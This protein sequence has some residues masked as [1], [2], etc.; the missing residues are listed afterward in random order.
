MGTLLTL[1]KYFY[2]VYLPAYRRRLRLCLGTILI[3]VLLHVFT[4][5]QKFEALFGD[6]T[7]SIFGKCIY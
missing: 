5:L 7:D 1:V 2:C 6:P 4:S 3:L